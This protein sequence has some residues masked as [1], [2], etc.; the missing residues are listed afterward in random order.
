MTTLYCAVRRARS[1][2][3][4]LLSYLPSWL[5]VLSAVGVVGAVSAIGA[6][7]AYREASTSSKT[8]SVPSKPQ[9]K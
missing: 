2:V 1:W 6:V 9:S 5:V 7:L 4:T 3:R 8:L